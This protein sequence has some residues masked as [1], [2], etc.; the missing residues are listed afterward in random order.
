MR[1]N[2]WLVPVSGAGSWSER[3]HLDVLDKHP[4]EY[5]HFKSTVLA[6]PLASKSRSRKS[7]VIV[8]DYA[9]TGTTV[10]D[11]QG[12]L[13]ESRI[14]NG[15]LYFINVMSMEDPHGQPHIWSVKTLKPI[16]VGDDHQRR[17]LTEGGLGRVVPPYPWFY[18]D[19]D[20]QQVDY[21]E[22]S[23]AQDLIDAIHEAGSMASN[24]LPSSANTTIIGNGTSIGNSSSIVP[25]NTNAT[26]TTIDS[27]TLSNDTA[28]DYVIPMPPPWPIAKPQLCVAN[29]ST[30][31]LNSPYS[32]NVTS[33][34]NLPAAVG[35]VQTS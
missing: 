19:V 22:K 26:T 25:A 17:I 4:V 10:I 12:I 33:N 24:T 7:R 16:D 3:R 27:P 29:E 15:P 34:T 21:P 14:W 30:S 9:R 2:A 32:Q 18:W 5:G 20:W 11:L 35:S 6:P 23:R 13:R 28:S 1:R 8:I 31:A